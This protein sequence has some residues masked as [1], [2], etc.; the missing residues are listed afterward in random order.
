MDNLYDNTLCIFFLSDTLPCPILGP[1]VPLFGISS[2][3]SFGLQSKSMF[4]LIR[5]GG[6]GGVMYIA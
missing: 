2:D 6:T 1:L 4:C 5:S 3:V